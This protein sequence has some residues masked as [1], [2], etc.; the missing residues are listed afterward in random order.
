M[1]VFLSIARNTFRECF[2]TNVFFVLLVTCLMLI[3]LFPLLSLFVFNEQYKMIIDSSLA[4]SLFFGL[5]MS[6]LLASHTFYREATNGTLLLLLSKPVPRYVFVTAKVFGVLMTLTFFIVTCC[7]ASLNSLTISISQFQT[8]YYNMAIFYGSLI[9]AAI[10]G[11]YRD[12]FKGTVFSESASLATLFFLVIQLLQNHFFPIGEISAK[13]SEL[14]S[15]MLPALLLILFAVWILGTI[16]IVF[17]T[18]FNLIINLML[19]FPVYI[20][21]LMS[22]YLI[23]KYIA[24]SFLCKILYAIVPNWQYFWMADSIS[25]GIAIPLEYIIWAFVYTM[26]Y[27]SVCVIIATV[28]FKNKELGSDRM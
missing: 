4:I 15:L 27:I 19:S 26:L 25:N 6:V 14:Q 3:G 28:L 21:G 2:R 23:G 18:R 1:L 24:S 20:L 13:I 10:W 17:S 11:A 16:T 7:I 5:L 8:N 22:H 9:L 12:Y